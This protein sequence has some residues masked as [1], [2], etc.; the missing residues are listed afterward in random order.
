MPYHAQETDFYCGPAVAQMALERQGVRLS[1]QELAEKLGTTEALGTTLAQLRRVFSAY[2]FDAAPKNGATL[3]DIARALRKGKTVI[4]G[5]IEPQGETPHYALVT[6]YQGG[7]LHLSDPWL[8][9]NVQIAQEK[10]E[11]RWRDDANRAYGDRAMLA[12]A[13]ASLVRRSVSRFFSRA[14]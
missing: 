11:R 6:S 12:L 2:G 8:G 13:P 9:E 3:P 4:V 14:A 1:Q 7:V 5:Y 10:F